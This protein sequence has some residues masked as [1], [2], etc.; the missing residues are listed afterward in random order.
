MAIIT[1]DP[2]ETEKEIISDGDPGD[3]TGNTQEHPIWRKAALES[4]SEFGY[5]D[6][7]PQDWIRAHLE[8]TVLDDYQRITRKE[9]N[10]ISFDLLRKMDGFREI[11]LTEHNRHLKTCRNGS[12][13][14]TRPNDQTYEVMQQFSR[15]FSKA[16][17]NAYRGL[18]HI[19]Q[20]ALTLEE[21][22]R[23]DDAKAKL[24]YLKTA[25]RKKPT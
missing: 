7:I 3:L 6:V 10:R 13:L 24:A 5:G 11:L 23:N 17:T 16:W 21:S 14:I 18:T 15:D 22:T 2:S 19:N 8:I 4:L 9:H 20:D 25:G 1:Q 12:Y